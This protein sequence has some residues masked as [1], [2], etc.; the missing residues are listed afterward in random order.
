MGNKYPHPAK[1]VTPYTHITKCVTAYPHCQPK[2]VDNSPKLIHMPE[3]QPTCVMGLSMTLSRKYNN[4]QIMASTLTII[5]LP[6]IR[7]IMRR[8]KS[9]LCNKVFCVHFLSCRTATDFCTNLY[10]FGCGYAVQ[11]MRN[12][13]VN[14]WTTRPGG[15]RGLPARA[16]GGVRAGVKKG[17]FV[18]LVG[19]LP[20]G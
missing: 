4:R 11:G 18:H 10:R 20:H 1:C 2:I 14:R 17:A 9:R 15:G 7:N 6:N 12:R 13:L 8:S 5:N 16:G 3:P 19:N